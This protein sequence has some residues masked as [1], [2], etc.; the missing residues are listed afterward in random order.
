M[1]KI[2]FIRYCTL[3]CFVGLLFSSNTPEN[4]ARKMIHKMER[5]I[6][7]TPEQKD[8]LLL[9]ATIFIRNTKAVNDSLDIS[10]KLLLKNEFAQSYQFAIDSILTFNQQ[11]E[12][13]RKE[14]ERKEIIIKSH[15]NN[16]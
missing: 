8:A 3:L 1:E 4:S 11:E 14:E 12:L 2:K 10:E 6:T 13:K 16:R 7:L 9:K 5:D 15:L